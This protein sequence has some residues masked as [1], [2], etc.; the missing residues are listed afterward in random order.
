[1]HR[2]EHWPPGASFPSLGHRGPSR[3]GG[4][5]YGEPREEGGGNKCRAPSKVC[6]GE[7]DVEVSVQ[8][9]LYCQELS[10][11]RRRKWG[12]LRDLEVWG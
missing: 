10:A 1:M 12:G 7:E 6:D 3:E 4:A 5:H 2:R 8:G 11:E 9:L